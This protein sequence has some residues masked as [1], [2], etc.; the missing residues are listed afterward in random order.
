[1]RVCLVA[2][3]MVL[4]AV[5]ST[6]EAQTAPRRSPSSAFAF[7]ITPYVAL[8]FHGVRAE[9]QGATCNSLPNGCLE[10]KPGSS[11]EV[12][13]GIEAPLFGSFGLGVLAAISRPSRVLCDRERCAGRGHVT[14]LRG[15]G[16]LQFRMKPRAPIFFGLGAVIARFDPSPVTGENRVVTET[17]FAGVIGYDFALGG[18][19]G[20][21]IAWYSY[22]M[23]PED[24]QTPTLKASSAY[25][26]VISFGARIRLGR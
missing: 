26:A 13:I 3:L 4:L 7:A 20:G 22:I 9:T 19:V 15:T 1:M 25:D 11:P 8:G 6:A 21:R 2:G 10:L 17:G 24:L 16:L 18:R 23:R 12:G 5:L 14:S